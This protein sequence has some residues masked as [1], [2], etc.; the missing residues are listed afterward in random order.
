MRK[1]KNLVDFPIRG[2]DMNY[3]THQKDPDGAI[4]DLTGVVHHFGGLNSGHYT[5]SVLNPINDEWLYYDDQKVSKTD[6][7]SL[8][9]KTATILFY[10]KREE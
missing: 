10:K 4:Y 8:V 5:A 7:E 2:L 6:E 9:D 3:H 1:I